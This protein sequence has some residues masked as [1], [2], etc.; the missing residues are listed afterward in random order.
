[1]RV[2]CGGGVVDVYGDSGYD[3]DNEGVDHSE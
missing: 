2:I 1:M 3:R